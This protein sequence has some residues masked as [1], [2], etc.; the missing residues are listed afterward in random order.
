MPSKGKGK[1]T[2]VAGKTVA[3]GK[4]RAVVVPPV[5]PVPPPG[6]AVVAS[7]SSAAVVAS[8]LAAAVPVRRR[9]AVRAP[10]G[11]SPHPSRDPDTAYTGCEVAC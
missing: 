7:N 4:A 8:S 6:D 9:R 2:A 3:K 11:Y 1:G 5:A 10:A